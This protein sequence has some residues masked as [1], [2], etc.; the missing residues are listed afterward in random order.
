M[1]ALLAWDKLLWRM[2]WLHG[3][4]VKRPDLRGTWRARL[5]SDWRDPET[6][7]QPAPIDGFVAITQTFSSLEFRL[8]TAES[9]SWF[10]VSEIRESMKGGGYQVFGVYMN[11]PDPALRGSR[12]EIHF[13]SLAL[14]THGDAQRPAS[15]SGEYWTDRGTKGTMQLSDRT[16][17]VYTQ[18]NTASSRMGSSDE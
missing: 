13:G 9:E 6:E 15:L 7:R 4:F 12:S 1:L 8:L 5:V 18:F 10:L 11:Q 14:D 17:S 2:A 16:A 3:W